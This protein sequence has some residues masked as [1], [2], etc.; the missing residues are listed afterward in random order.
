VERIEIIL[1]LALVAVTIYTLLKCRQYGQRVP[2]PHD[3][4]QM[5]HLDRNIEDMMG[6]EE[7][8]E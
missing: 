6:P 1:S 3:M 7:R 4:I 8:D 5:N 2:P